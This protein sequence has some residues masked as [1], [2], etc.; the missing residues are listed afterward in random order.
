MNDTVI[1]IMFIFIAV[2]LLWM[3]FIHIYFLVDYKKTETESEKLDKELFLK[4]Q[5]RIAN[6]FCDDYDVLSLYYEV[7]RDCCTNVGYVL[8]SEQWSE[9]ERKLLDGV[10]DIEDIPQKIRI[11]NEMLYAVALRYAR[12]ANAEKYIKICETLKKDISEC[13]CPHCKFLLVNLY[14]DKGSFVPY[15]KYIR[16]HIYN[17][18]EDK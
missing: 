14:I 6:N 10:I 2:M 4:M 16:E 18:K 1:L 15:K 3:G 8:E 9:L 5:N 12:V 7:N 11:C 17:H 13:E